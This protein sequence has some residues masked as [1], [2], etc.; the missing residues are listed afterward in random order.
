MTSGVRIEHLSKIHGFKFHEECHA[1]LKTHHQLMEKR[2]SQRGMLL[3]GGW[4]DICEHLETEIGPAS[5]CED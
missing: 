4:Q 2:A 3:P 5:L 1:F